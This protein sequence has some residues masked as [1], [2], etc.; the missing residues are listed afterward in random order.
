MAGR[1]QAKPLKAWQRARDWNKPRNTVHDTLGHRNGETRDAAALGTKVVSG[2]W[3]LLW[4][5]S[6][7]DER[8]ENPPHVVKLQS[9]VI[10]VLLIRRDDRLEGT[11]EVSSP[12]VTQV[13]HTVLAPAQFL[14]QFRFTYEIRRQ[15]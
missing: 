6:H 11:R 15:G 7:R 10:P 1:G 13:H 5:F 14:T 2:F 4:I 9:Q 12:V 8:Q 3:L